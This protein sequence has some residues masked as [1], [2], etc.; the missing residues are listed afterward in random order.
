M[1]NGND[2]NSGFWFACVVAVRGVR[3]VFRP[4]VNVGST[5]TV[6]RGRFPNFYREGFVPLPVRGPHLVADFRF[7]SVFYCNELA[8]GGLLE[9]FDRARVLHCALGCFRAGV[10]RVG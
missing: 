10:K 7:L 9:N 4:L 8:C 6:F 5:F 1:L 3:F 2:A